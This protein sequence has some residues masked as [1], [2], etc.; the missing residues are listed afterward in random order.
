MNTL[1]LMLAR[2]Y[3]KFPDNFRVMFDDAPL[4]ALTRQLF[5]NLD[6]GSVDATPV[7]GEVTISGSPGGTRTE[8]RTFPP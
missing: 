4:P 1:F 7:A 8:Y 2:Y 3:L 6:V 5:S